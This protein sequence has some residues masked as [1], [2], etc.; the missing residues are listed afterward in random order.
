MQRLDAAE[1]REVL[2]LGHVTGE[3]T[4]FSQ[5]GTALALL[6][7]VV[8]SDTATLTQLDLQTGHEVALF[9][10][11]ERARTAR[12]EEYVRVGHLHPLRAVLARELPR[13]AGQR[14]VPRISD[15]LS[16]HGWRSHPVRAAMP[17]VTDQMAALLSGR[18]SVL[19]AVTLGRLGGRFSDKQRDL[20]AAAGPLLAAPLARSVRAGHR[21]LQLAPQARW[22]PADQAPG[23]EPTDAGARPGTAVAEAS[24]D[25]PLSAR[26]LEVLELV[27]RGNTDAQVARRLGL[28]PATVSKHLSRIYGR[29]GVPNR[30]AAVQRLGRTPSSLG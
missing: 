13:R 11:L 20:L 17:D 18:Q 12:L 30:A 27:A 4:Q 10:P 25:L 15:Q 29:L 14:V 6:A 9:W 22:V 8:G 23:W 21:A 5:L 7:G 28:R 1:L 24:P 3:L 16:Q 26:E 19:H 2:A